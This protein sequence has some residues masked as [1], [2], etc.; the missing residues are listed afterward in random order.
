LCRYYNPR[1]LP[2]PPP[3]PMPPSGPLQK[4]QKKTQ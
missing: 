2:L 4:R 3:P 1:K